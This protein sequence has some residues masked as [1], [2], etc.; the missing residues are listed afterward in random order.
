MDVSTYLAWYSGL[1]DCDE[2]FSEWARNEKLHTQK[3]VSVE[4]LNRS[5][6]TYVRYAE[7]AKTKTEG[8]KLAELAVKQAEQQLELHRLRSPVRGIVREV[9]KVRGE[10]VKALESVIL[11]EALE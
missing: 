2:A 6:L 9:Y 7:E 11:I 4:E 3:I 8:V 10:G 1:N 5:K